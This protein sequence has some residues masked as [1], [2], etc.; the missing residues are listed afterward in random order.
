MN[1]LFIFHSHF[2][3]IVVLAG[4]AVCIKFL[5]GW[6]GQKS[7]G[8]ADQALFKIYAGIID[9]QLLTGLLFLFWSGLSSAGFPRY[10]I[11]HTF[12]MLIVV[13]L[14]HLF[15][16]WQTAADPIRFR[17]GFVLILLSIILIFIGVLM[18]PAG[19]QRWTMGT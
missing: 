18:L 9:L 7:F 17:N 1:I 19:L 5:Y 3:W 15:K 14:A 4:L 16:R 8:K 10:R 12:I 2:R 13:V 6:L 11:E